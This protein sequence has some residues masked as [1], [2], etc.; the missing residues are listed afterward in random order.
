MQL[1]EPNTALPAQMP[2][3]P[4]R[5]MH[6]EPPRI[7]LQTLEGMVAEL[8]KTGIAMC[9]L[10]RAGEGW[11]LKALG[12]VVDGS[13]SN[14]PLLLAAI[15]ELATDTGALADDVPAA[16]A[17][18][19]IDQWVEAV[20]RERVLLLQNPKAIVDAPPRDLD[21]RKLFSGPQKYL[22]V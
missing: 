18:S 20:G 3:P 21:P 22:L 14:Y 8:T 19:I 1:L 10:F 12:D 6:K 13:A 2:T 9:V 7:P 17:K 4:P 11:A 16:P 5:A 15:K